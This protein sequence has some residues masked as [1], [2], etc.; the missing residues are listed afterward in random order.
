MAPLPPNS[1]AQ[2]FVDY[3]AATRN[4]TFGVRV[5]GLESPSAFGTHLHSFLLAVSPEFY[6]IT[7]NAVRFQAAGT[8]FSSPVVTGEE[9]TI[10]GTGTPTVDQAPF[11]LNFRGRT[12]GGRRS[13]LE[14]FGYKGIT[15]SWRITDAE[16][17]NVAAGL[18]V[19][20]AQA[21]AWLGIDGLKPVWYPYANVVHN[22]YW[23]R[24][25]RV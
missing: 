18:A 6:P 17:V 25:V 5:N 21:N 9:G 22:A 11:A 19:V 20:I 16:N 13:G 8:N 7:I 15:S 10:F 23:Q 1:T 12:S 4:H 14:P 24:K 3:S 2:F